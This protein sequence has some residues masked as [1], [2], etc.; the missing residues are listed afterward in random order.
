MQ[1]VQFEKHTDRNSCKSGEQQ[2]KDCATLQA[3]VVVCYVYGTCTQYL[4]LHRIQEGKHCKEL[5][6]RVS[7]MLL[8]HLPPDTQTNESDQAERLQADKGACV[9]PAGKTEQSR[10]DDRSI[11]DKKNDWQHLEIYI[12][13]QYVCLN[14]SV[15]VHVDGLEV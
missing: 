4:R 9:H 13:L 15:H 14:E 1:Q 10:P 11:N 6:Q 2:L 12:V 8:H 3:L 7:H 5:T